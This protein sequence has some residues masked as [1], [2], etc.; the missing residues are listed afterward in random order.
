MKGRMQTAWLVMTVV[1]IVL[2]IA[3]VFWPALEALWEAVL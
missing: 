2:L 1:S 3:H